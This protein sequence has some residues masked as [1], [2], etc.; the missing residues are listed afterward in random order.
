MAQIEED[1]EQ[2]HQEPDTSRHSFMGFTFCR[3]STTS[4]SLLTKMACEVEQQ[5]RFTLQWRDAVQDDQLKKYGVV[6]F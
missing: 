5:L 1:L 3:I 2:H 4:L 6:I